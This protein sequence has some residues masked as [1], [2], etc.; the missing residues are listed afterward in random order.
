MVVLVFSPVFQVQQPTMQVVVVVERIKV[1]L[2]LEGPVEV[3]PGLL[4]VVH[5][6]LQVQ[7]IL[8]VAAVAQT[9]LV[10]IQVQVV[11]AL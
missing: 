6:E 1:L 5:R 8:A 2:V 9:I 10:A 4:V 3:A 11:P 7:L